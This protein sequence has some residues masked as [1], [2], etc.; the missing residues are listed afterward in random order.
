M[1][2]LPQSK[3]V[4][5]FNVLSAYSLEN[6]GLQ[7]SKQVYVAGDDKEAR[8]AVVGVIRAAGFTPVDSGLLVSARKIE[9]IPVSVFIQWRAPFYIHLAIFIFLYALWFAKA[10]ICWPITWGNGN[11]LWQLWNHIPM[12]NVNKTLA[13]HSLTMLALCYL[14]GVLAGWLQIFRG[15]KYSRFPNWLDNWLKM[16]KQLGI[17]MLFAASIHA[18]LSV[19]YMAP[20]YNYLIYGDAVQVS[21]HV[22]EGEGWGPRT[23]S[24]NRTVVKVY[25]GEKMTWKEF[26][27]IQ[28]GL[29][30]VAMILLCAHDMFYGWKYINGPSCGIPSSFQ[31]VL[32][33]PFLTILLKLPLVLPPLSTHLTKI[34]AG[35]VRSRNTK[36]QSPSENV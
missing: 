5:S 26:A 19:A 7:G 20:R 28:S 6:G 11:F 9:D 2:M 3:V 29:G 32:Y 23:E 8:E 35:Y 10:Q 33:V 16:R 30:W 24:E 31:Y 4:K 22:M 25:G 34:R 27:F 36:Q 14:P 1:G 21:V 15:T 12:D 13:V 17:L 18:C